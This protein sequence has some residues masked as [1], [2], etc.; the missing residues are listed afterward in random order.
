MNTVL[1]YVL[2]NHENFVM[3]ADSQVY[4]FRKSFDLPKIKVR[5]RTGIENQ[6]FCQPSFVLI[7]CSRFQIWFSAIVTREW[8]EKGS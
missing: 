4:K 1:P 8:F 7:S 3:Q 2:I 5:D 6:V